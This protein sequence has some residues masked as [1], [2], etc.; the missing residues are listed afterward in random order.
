MDNEKDF[1][2]IMI[3]GGDTITRAIAD[4]CSH[5]GVLVPHPPPDL[6][7]AGGGRGRGKAT[8]PTAI[9]EGLK[10]EH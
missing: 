9:I 10:N 3:I 4:A 1:K 5:S 8:T 6:L 7:F 2:Q